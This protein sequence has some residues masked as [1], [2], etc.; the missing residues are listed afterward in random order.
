MGSSRSGNSPTRL[1]LEANVVF[2]TRAWTSQ[3]SFS[4][5]YV[6]GNKSVTMA[7]NV[8]YL[9]RGHG[10]FRL[11]SSFRCSNRSRRE[12]H[13]RHLAETRNTSTLLTPARK[14]SPSQRAEALDIVLVVPEP[15]RRGRVT[16]PVDRDPQSSTPPSSRPSDD[17]TRD[18]S[19]DESRCRPPRPPAPLRRRPRWPWWVDRFSVGCLPPG[20]ATA[21][22]VPIRKSQSRPSP[23]SSALSRSVSVAVSD[24]L[25]RRR[26]AR[27][28]PSR[29][30][31]AMSA[32][33]DPPQERGRRPPPR[34]AL[35]PDPSSAIVG[36]VV[37]TAHEPQS[38]P[39][40]EPPSR[41]SPQTEGISR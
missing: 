30:S 6:I 8:L 16:P 26:D 22:F 1:T 2:G 19:R 27:P 39:A 15:G 14:G 29:T 37:D 34:G 18:A 21:L 35:D 4:F 31:T 3:S 20:R 28:S 32:L 24:H 23:N 40:G 10:R 38:D 36:G 41:L 13:A 5:W 25:G 7:T 17:V 11:L 33:R 9:D 12:K